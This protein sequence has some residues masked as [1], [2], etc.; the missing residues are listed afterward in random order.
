MDSDSYL[1]DDCWESIF[2]LIINDDD[3]NHN[4]HYL[5]IL[6]LVCKQFLSITNS[7]RFSYTVSNSSIISL[8]VSHTVYDSTHSFFRHLF[9]RYTNLNTLNT[10]NLINRNVFIDYDKLLCQISCFPFK[11]TSLNLS[12]VPTFP[13]NGLRAFAQKITT[14]TSLTCSHI[15]SLNSS[16]LFL[17]AEYF[18]LLEEL[19]LSYPKGCKKSSSYVDG[20]EA[21]SLALIKLRKVN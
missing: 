18:P 3:Y 16:D 15:H 7:L 8:P 14:L 13:A 12:Q 4:C 6:S 10:L 5:N 20:V 11:L 1:S 19:D 9:I 2:R 21:L 17:I